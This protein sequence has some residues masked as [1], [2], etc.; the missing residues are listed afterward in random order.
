MESSLELLNKKNEEKWVD[1]LEVDHNATYSMG[2]EFLVY[3]Q[4][5]VTIRET[6]ERHFNNIMLSIE[7]DQPEIEEA[8]IVEEQKQ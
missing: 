1:K 7:R 3:K 6:L 5:I 4:E 8:K 2:N